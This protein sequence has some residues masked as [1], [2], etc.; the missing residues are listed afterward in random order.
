MDLLDNPWTA[1]SKNQNWERVITTIDTVN[2]LVTFDVPLTNSLDNSPDKNYGGGTFKHYSWSGGSRI[3]QSGVSDMYL[4]SDGNV[5]NNLAH[6]SGSIQMDDIVNGWIHNITSDGFSVNQIVLSSDAKYCTIDDAIVQNTTVSSQAPPAGVS[7]NGQLNLAENI[8][9][10]GV[11][12]AVALGATVPGPNVISN[13]FADGTG[14]DCGPHQ[15]WST[16]GLFDNVT[17][18]GNDLQ[19]NNRGNSGSGHGWAGANYVL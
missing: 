15:R 1:G 8:T 14:S 11:Y 10:H 9:E 4:Y 18:V 19:A 7:I 3:T 2:K 16:G 12:H 17:V 13:L 6:A 5:A